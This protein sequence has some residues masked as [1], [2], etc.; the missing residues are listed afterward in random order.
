MLLAAA[1]AAASSPFHA[2]FSAA[3]GYYLLLLLLLHV[4]EMTDVSYAFNAAP[5]VTLANL[6]S[7]A[8]IRLCRYPVTWP[9]LNF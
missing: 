4:G 1:A 5:E 2:G 3:D 7:A 8:K 6:I 9:A